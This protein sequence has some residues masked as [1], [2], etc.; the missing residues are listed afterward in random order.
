MLE[1]SECSKPGDPLKEKSKAENNKHNSRKRGSSKHSDDEYISHKRRNVAVR[2]S[3]YF[4]SSP[5]GTKA[6]E[7]EECSDRS[8]VHEKSDSIPRNVHRRNFYADYNKSSERIKSHRSS[9]RNKSESRNKDRSSMHVPANMNSDRRKKNENKSSRSREE[10]KE[11]QAQFQ[12]KL[13]KLENT[14]KAIEKEVIKMKEIIEKNLNAESLKILEILLKFQNIAEENK[15]KPQPF[16]DGSGLP[17]VSFVR[18]IPDSN[19]KEVQ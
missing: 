6:T 10:D 4:N 19:N 17:S 8:P 3:S 5:P 12:K 9:D 14:V 15:T 13:E 1:F 11:V 7:S 16:F 2:D 18:R